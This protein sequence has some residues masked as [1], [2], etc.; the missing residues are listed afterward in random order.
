MD[1]RV[2]HKTEMSDQVHVTIP[3]SVL[4]EQRGRPVTLLG[5]LVSS[6]ACVD[7][8][9]NREVFS[10]DGNQSAIILSVVSYCCLSYII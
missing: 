8:R 4:K 10:P 1:C 7:V 9:A 3:L 2:R 6:W 5:G